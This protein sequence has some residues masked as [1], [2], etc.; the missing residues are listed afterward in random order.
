MKNSWSM[1]AMMIVGEV[2][3]TGILG[4]PKAAAT[5]G[6]ALTVATLLSFGFFSSYSGTLLARL[7][8]DFFPEA[9]SYADMARETVGG[10]FA[11]FTRFLIVGNWVLL[12]P[13]YVVA[14]GSSISNVAG[15]LGDG[16]CGYEWTLIFVC[17]ALPFTQ[18][19]TLKGV[20]YLATLSVIAI[21]VAT[22]MLGV[23]IVRDADDPNGAN[24]TD[25]SFGAGTSFGPVFPSDQ[26]PFRNFFSFY[27]AFSSF[28]FAYQGQD[29]FTELIDDMRDTKEASKAVK[30]SYY[31]MTV[32]YAAIV[33][34]AYGSDGPSVEGFLP[35][36][37]HSG[38]AKVITNALI[39]F[40]VLVAYVITGNLTVQVFYKW[41]F[42]SL[43]LELASLGTWVQGVQVRLRW[44]L[45]TFLLLAFSYVLAN[46][47]P[48][49]S[50]LQALIGALAGAP[51]VF[52]FPP[53]F[54]L[55]A[56]RQAGIVGRP[57]ANFDAIL[58][59]LFLFILLPSFTILGTI[60]AVLD[61]SDALQEA[62]T[63]FTC[64]NAM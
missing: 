15:S 35:D 44:L 5:L 26:T 34:T 45:L 54:Y 42:R 57:L 30:V 17:C 49:F 43:P 29:I 3:G 27:A 46:V 4:L 14:A 31:F 25:S 23:A 40:H 61:I 55:L 10:R 13:Y 11:S 48:A 53:L 38:P 21:I 33:V 6:W 28:V 62:G 39:A 60:G 32:T 9:E 51:I 63:P 50:A 59:S 64:S 37:L 58:C 12:L 8:N 41:M 52:G 7:K 36:A 20:S 16:I 18:F 19:T 56:H 2:L 47:V 22:V 1:T 24:I